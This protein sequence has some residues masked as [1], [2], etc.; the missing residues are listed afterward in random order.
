LTASVSFAPEQGPS[1]AR[2]AR[3]GGKRHGH[4]KAKIA[5]A[6]WREQDQPRYGEKRQAR[7]GTQETRGR[8]TRWQSSSETRQ[9]S[10]KKGD[11][12]AC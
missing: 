2:S 12:D 6:S 9:E 7:P 10:R 5:Q 3:P 1:L 4:E 8:K 11:Q